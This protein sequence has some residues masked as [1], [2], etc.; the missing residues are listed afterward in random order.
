MVKYGEL[1]A[2]HLEDIEDS[3]RN[4]QGISWSAFQTWMTLLDIIW[5]NQECI[6]KLDNEYLSGSTARLED[7]VDFEEWKKMVLRVDAEA[8]LDPPKGR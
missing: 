6:S 1:T 4:H 3:L 7:G 8:R 5:M 2:A